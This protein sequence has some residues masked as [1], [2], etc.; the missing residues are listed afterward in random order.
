M[1]HLLGD[2]GQA[3]RQN[4]TMNVPG[5]LYHAA[6]FVLPVRGGSLPSIVP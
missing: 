2:D 6:H 1:R 4:V 5:F 3:I